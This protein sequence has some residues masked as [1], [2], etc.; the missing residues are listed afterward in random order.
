VN[1]EA[2]RAVRR[3]AGLFR[4]PAR[5]L[6][7]VRGGDRLRFL[8]GQLSNEVAGLE[9]GG[10]RSGCY[11][12]VLT[13]QGRIVADLHVMARPDAVWLETAREAV[14]RALARLEKY[15]IADDVALADRSAALDRL[16][17]EG[18][19]A[20]AILRT[21][22]QGGALPAPDQAAVLRI[23]GAEVVVAAYGWSGEAAF[24]LLAPAGAGPAME[25]ALTGAGR[26]AG[27]HVADAETLEVLRVEAGIPVQGRE[28][29]EDTLPAEARLLA[30]AVSFTKGCYTGQ[31][32]VARMASR[33]R[34]GHLLV[35]IVFEDASAPPSAPGA[36]IAVGG[37]PVGAVT[38]AVRSPVAG[39]IALG[40]VRSAH[41]EPGT[42]LEVDGRP[43][44]VA[45]LP[46]V[47]PTP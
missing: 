42:A 2:A 38:S 24:Q 11:A 33:R 15:V 37:H 18:P 1:A 17:L 8:N 41:A 34:L 4:L 19:G 45:A 47:D 26:E 14:P 7:E 29:G 23:G 12:L 46:F 31:E 9:P 16:G 32:V 5:G 28:L 44:H 25:E 3:A 30:R 40:F 21:A 6:L 36:R 20:P 10:P 13:P 22:A 35:G 43:A 39:P 27:L